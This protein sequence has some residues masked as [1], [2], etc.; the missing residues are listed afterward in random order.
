MWADSENTRLKDEM[1]ALAETAKDIVARYC[2]DSLK[3][4]FEYYVA[5]ASSILSRMATLIKEHG[6]YTGNNREFV[7]LMY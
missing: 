1:K 3:D 7:A 5:N 2:S 6:L 4:D